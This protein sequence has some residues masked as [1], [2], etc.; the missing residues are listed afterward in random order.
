MNNRDNDGV[1][2]SQVAG[3]VLASFFGVQ[4]SKNRE[5]DFQSGKFGVFVAMGAVMTFLL[6]VSIYTVVVLVLP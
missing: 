5:R 1:S 3:S 2:I 4:S 6:A